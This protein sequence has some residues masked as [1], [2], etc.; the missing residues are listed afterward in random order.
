MIASKKR[1]IAPGR[2]GDGAMGLLAEGMVDLALTAGYNL[3]V[4]V[5]AA[6]VGDGAAGLAGALAGALALAAA[7]VGQGL[8]QAGLRDGLD[9]LCTVHYTA[10]RG[11]FQD[12]CGGKRKAA[13]AGEKGKR[14]V[15][16]PAAGPNGYCRYACG[17]GRYGSV[18]MM[19]NCIALC[20]THYGNNANRSRRRCHGPKRTGMS[21]GKN[22]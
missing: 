1:R 13:F 19:I 11:A 12:F 17:H 6:L 22:R 14:R 15:W 9:S 4:L 21:L 7:A 5:G 3:I 20:H 2:C 8:T 16:T 10:C 18:I